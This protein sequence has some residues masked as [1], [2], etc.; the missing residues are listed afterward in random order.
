[1]A[2][3]HSE[4]YFKQQLEES[5]KSKTLYQDTINAMQTEE[6]FVNF[7]KGY[8]AQS[9][10]GFIKHYATMKAIWYKHAESNYRYNISKKSKWKDEDVE[11]LKIIYEKKLF[12]LNFRWKA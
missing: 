3:N 4:E 1:M 10:E 5:E 9:V 8:N 2:N 6:R 7:F 12:S 11:L